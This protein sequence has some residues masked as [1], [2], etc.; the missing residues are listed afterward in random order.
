MEAVREDWAKL[1]IP[2]ANSTTRKRVD[3]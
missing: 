1:R 3:L 2:K